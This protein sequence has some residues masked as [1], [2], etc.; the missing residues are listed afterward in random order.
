MTMK[1]STFEEIQQLMAANHALRFE[2]ILNQLDLATTFA[3]RAEAA[4][5]DENAARNLEYARQAYK[6]ANHFMQTA[7]PEPDMAEY[8]NTK[9]GRLRTLLEKLG[10]HLDQCSEKQ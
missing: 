9:L 10:Q 3:K 5:S 8:I 4:W 1:D 6:A 7:T 2:F